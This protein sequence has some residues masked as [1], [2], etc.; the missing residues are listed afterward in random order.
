[1]VLKIMMVEILL[2]LIIFTKNPA[3]TAIIM[4]SKKYHSDSFEK[5]KG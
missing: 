3:L 2:S 4:E 5:C 1:M